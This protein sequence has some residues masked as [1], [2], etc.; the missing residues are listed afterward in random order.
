MLY[1]SKKQ[2]DLLMKK[3]YKIHFA[4]LLILLSVVFSYGQDIAP[5]KELSAA[6]SSIQK[7]EASDRWVD[8]F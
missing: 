8:K 3:N 4:A 6:S 7:I 5:P 1:F 2:N